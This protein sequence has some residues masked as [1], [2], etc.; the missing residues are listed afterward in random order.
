MFLRMLILFLLGGLLTFVL[1]VLQMEYRL[2]LFPNNI[3]MFFQT[4]WWVI[5]LCGI[6]AGIS[7]K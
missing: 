6:G 1:N 7:I 4:T 3:I 5:P 2:N